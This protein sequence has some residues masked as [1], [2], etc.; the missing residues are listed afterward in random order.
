MKHLKSLAAGICFFL[1]A[2]CSA[3]K[4]SPYAMPGVEHQP[5]HGMAQLVFY[6]PQSFFWSGRTAY[7]ALGDKLGKCTVKPGTFLIRDI[8]PDTTT[9]ITATLCGEPASSQLILKTVPG[10]QYFIRISP[11]DNSLT[12]RL[13]HMGMAKTKEQLVYGGPFRL[14]IMG[15][16]QAHEELQ[17]LNAS[18]TSPP[19]GT[20]Q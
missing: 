8:K 16:A 12:G 15:E 11:N 7:L 18:D 20:M 3:D 6:Y 9:T 2:A 1:L 14:D 13:G 5:P 4:T 19:P 10:M 17:K